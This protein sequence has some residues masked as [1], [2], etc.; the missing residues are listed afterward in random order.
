MIAIVAGG[1]SSFLA[2]PTLLGVGSRA[3]IIKLVLFGPRPAQPP[4]ILPTL[5]GG[6]IV[7]GGIVAWL[8]FWL[9]DKKIY[10]RR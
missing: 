10:P 9:L 1:I 6:S 8:V 4:W 5:I 7:V 2:Y 3:G